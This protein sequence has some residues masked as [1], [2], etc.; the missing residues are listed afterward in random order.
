MIEITVSR[1]PVM[2]DVLT[3]M[4]EIAKEIIEFVGTYITTKCIVRRTGGNPAS[5]TSTDSRGNGAVVTMQD[6]G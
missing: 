5:I 2:K 3:T 1:T 4:S 6:A